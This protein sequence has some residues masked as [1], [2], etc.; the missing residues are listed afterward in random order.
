MMPVDQSGFIFM[1]FLHVRCSTSPF[2]PTGSPFQR[3]D[4][5]SVKAAQYSISAVT[6]LSAVIRTLCDF[7]DELSFRINGLK[8]HSH[9]VG[10]PAQVL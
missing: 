6:F 8:R 3:A 2:T 9:L 7:E 10:N 5:K 4:T 1:P